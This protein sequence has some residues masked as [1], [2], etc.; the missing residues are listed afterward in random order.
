MNLQE[1]TEN[2]I[3]KNLSS[4]II[5]LLN[6]AISSKDK[7]IICDIEVT[8]PWNRE[9]IESDKS[10]KHYKVLV[11]FIGGY[12]TNRWPHTQAIMQEEEKILND[13]HTLIS[14]FFG[15]YVDMY[16]RQVKRCDKSLNEGIKDKW[17]RDN[18]TISLRKLLKVTNDVPIT[19]MLTKKLMK[20][21]L[22]GDNPK[23]MNKIEK[24]NLQ[25]PILILVNDDNSIKYI[26]DG[27]HRI[28]KANKH[29]IKWI[30][31]K[32]I[33]FSELPNNF[34]RVLGGEKEEETEGVGGY[35]AP[36]FEMKPDH[37]HFKHLYNEEVESN[38]P[39]YSPQ[40]L[41][42]MEKMV[43]NFNLSD[44]VDVKVEWVENQGLYNIK[45]YYKYN[46]NSNNILNMMEVNNAK[47]LT[48][49]H[50]FGLPPYSVS[51]RNYWI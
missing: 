47:L 40:T 17:T 50:F 4:A 28:Q 46:P 9:S 33:K 6:S 11:T 10:F 12:G 8:A 13:M 16:A 32:L 31:A 42:L 37:V 41:K 21:A 7:K 24:A 14:N 45:L 29:D 35:A 3:E 18:E 15:I 23:E 51:V 20:H 34:K 22:H 43:S 36:A 1:S 49:R 38:D 2:E 30:N 26:V 19:K 44:V 39:D 25:Y 48:I 5:K 27:H